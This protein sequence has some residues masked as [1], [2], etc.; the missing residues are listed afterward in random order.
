MGNHKTPS[1][2]TEQ[3]IL[4]SR[5]ALRGAIGAALEKAL[6]DVQIETVVDE[7]VETSSHSAPLPEFRAEPREA[8]PHELV[9]SSTT[10]H[11]IQ[12]RY[13]TIVAN[14]DW[15]AAPAATMKGRLDHYNRFQGQWR[16]VVDKSAEIAPRKLDAVI[17]NKNFKESYGNRT[18][19]THEG[20]ETIE[21][22]EKVQILVFNDQ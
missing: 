22:N 5:I 18:K 21:L 10:L 13:G 4:S 8:E 2:P 17:T 14:T 11:Y 19:S 9:I 12:S 1:L 20:L 7:Q 15:R 3:Q 16:I 6:E